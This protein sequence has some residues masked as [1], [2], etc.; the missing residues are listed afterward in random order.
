MSPAV[1][2]ELED[3]LEAFAL[4][5]AEEGALARYLRDYPQF[6]GPLVDLAHEAWR[7]QPDEDQPLDEAGRAAIEAGWSQLEKQWPAEGRNLFAGRAPAEYGRVANDLG[8]PR[9]LVSAIRDGKVLLETVPRTFLQR[10]ASALGGTLEDLRGS[11]GGSPALARS[12][13]SEERPSVQ[14]PVSFEQALIDA[15]VPEERQA[16]LLAEG[17]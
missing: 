5:A 2:P 6:A 11:I 4:E 1:H 14:P 12:Y 15:R 7:V 3:V 9:Q 10:F 16:Q 17:E 8:I 13:K